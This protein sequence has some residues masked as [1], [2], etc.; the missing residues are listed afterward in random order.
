MAPRWRADGGTE[1]NLAPLL[2]VIFCLLFFFVLA[3]SLRQQPQALE[4][5]VPTTGQPPVPIEKQERLEVT[6]TEDNRI[7]F[8]GKLVSGAELAEALRTAMG[9]SPQGR[10]PE[11]VFIRSDA[12]ADVQTFVEVS[13]ACAEA[14]IKAALMETLPKPP[15]GVE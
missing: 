5:Q 7:L 1:I 4:V 3:T 10:A 12:Q 2:D 11:E 6:I 9:R 14:G 13:D 15:E 8:D